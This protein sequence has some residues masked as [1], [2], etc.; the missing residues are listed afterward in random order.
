MKKISKL[1]LLLLIFLIVS[2]FT[3]IKTLAISNDDGTAT[4]EVSSTKNSFDTENSHYVTDIGKTTYNSLTYDQQVH[5]FTQAQTSDSKVV[6][7][8]VADDNGKLT[9]TNIAAIAADYEK[10]HPDWEVL[11]GINA[12]QYTTG[13]G[14]NIPS[15]GKDYYYPQPYYPMICDG[16]GWFIMTGIPVS[17][18]QNI[19]SIYNDGRTN[20]LISGSANLNSGDLDIAGMYLYILDEN[21]NRLAKFEINKFN[22]TPIETET[23]VWTSFFNEEEEFPEITVSGEHLYIVDE[24]IR[25]YATNSIDY[26]YKNNNAQ[27]A[28]FGKGYITQICNTAKIGYGDFAI[29]SKNETVIAALELG[30]KILVQYELK[31]EASQCESAIGFHTIQRMNDQDGTITASN[32]Y[33][34]RQYPRAIIGQKANGDIVLMAIDGIQEKKGYCGAN[35]WEANAILKNYG[36]VTAYQMDGGGSVTAI[37]KDSSGKFVVVN[38]PS[39]GSARSVLSGLFIVER[40]KPEITLDVSAINTT[41]VDLSINIDDHGNEISS[42]TIIINSQTYKITDMNQKIISIDLDHLQSYNYTIDVEYE[43]DKTYTLSGIIDVLAICPTLKNCSVEVLEEKSVYTFE[44]DDY[45][46]I[47]T[48]YCLITNGMKY[49]PK[50]GKIEIPN[51]KEVIY[52]RYTYIINN[53]TKTVTIAYPQ[54][55]G[56]RNI[57][58]LY[59]SV[60]GAIN[61][62]SLFN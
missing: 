23:A 57:H 21:D 33:N 56:L 15:Q 52:L 14:T 34:T 31:G 59:S 53:I 27:N 44:F 41:S 46:N 50:D 2:V 12:D 6:T 30:T 8:S 55:L 17:G 13:F 38:S 29:S 20:S 1:I 16:E 7:W 26:T 35:Y 49:D 9:R 25:A 51:T 37:I 58:E 47:L 28:F 54:S 40:K 45:D 48:S 61:S 39:D 24:A 3:S 11:G 18:G 36:V 22:E 43:V 60:V 19:V 5:V 62:T 32:T 42:Y 4:Y 10:N